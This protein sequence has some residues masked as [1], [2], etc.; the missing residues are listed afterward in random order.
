MMLTLGSGIFFSC[1]PEEG[2]LG[3]MDVS[4]NELVEGIAFT[5]EHDATNPNI[6]YLKSLM[7]N[8]YTPLWEHPQGR[9]QAKTVTLQMPFEGTY[10]VKF[11]VQTRGGIVYGEAVT[12]TIDDFYAGFVDHELW[13]FLTGGVG[14]SKV[15]IHDNGDYGMATGEMDYADPTTVVEWNNFSPNWSPGKGHTGDANIWEST[16]TFSLAGGANV[17]VH[18]VSST[19]TKDESGTFMLDVEN[20][21]ITFT[22][23]N[24]MHTQSWDFKTTNWARS[25]KILTLN[26]NQLRVAVLRELVS[27]EGEWWLIWNF[28]SKEY[29]DNYV[30]EDIPDPVPNIDGEPN[31]VLTTTKTKTWILSPDSPYDWTNLNGDLLNN[32]TGGEPTYLGTGWAAY[33]ADM[34]A[35]TKLTFTSKS[36]TGGS[37]VFSSHEND[38]VK[39][40]YSIDANHDIDFGQPLSAMISQYNFGWLST[41][42]LNTTSENKLRILKTKLDLLGFNVTDI[43]LGQRSTDKDEYMVYHFVLGSGSGAEP[44]VNDAWKE[45]LAGKTLKP[46]VNWFIDW[47]NFPPDFTGGWTSASTFGNDFTSNSWVWDANVRAVAE[48]ASLSFRME[49]SALK[50]DLTQTKNGSPFTA[51]GDVTLD[52]E[53]QLINISIPLVDYVGTAASWL[54][55][56]NPKSVSGSTNDWYIVSHGGATLANMATNGLWLGTVSNSIAAGD[57]K[58]EILAFHYLIAP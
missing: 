35:A 20:H 24:I 7:D 8:R 39:G 51:T 50:V 45:A 14:E 42:N 30:P 21:T 22:D 43:W 48:S 36:G 18:N 37:F 56:S 53:N 32:F 26:E 19:G 16:M 52:V 34:I 9:S 12:F 28:V 5:I 41:M 6:V 57:S 40:E 17:D 2:S 49:G 25:L 10:T 1:S 29:A 4:P 3:E 44:D 38:D 23:A 47:T 15:W 58:D 55:T 54:N 11:G 27:G 31:D 13:T 33:D 46:D